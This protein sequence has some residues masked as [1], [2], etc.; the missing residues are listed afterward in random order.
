MKEKKCPACEKGKLVPVDD[1][2]SEIE[3]YVFVEKGERCTHCGEEFINEKEGQ[4]MINLAK[5]LGVWGEPLKLYRKLSKSARGTVL[6]IPSD[7]EK[8]LGIKGGEEVAISKIGRK[9][10]IEVV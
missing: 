5:K 1:I 6:R 8:N 3:G 7:I 4:K 10:I 2:V 9:I